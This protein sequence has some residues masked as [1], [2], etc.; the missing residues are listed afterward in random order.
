MSSENAPHSL[1]RWPHRS[2]GAALTLLSRISSTAASNSLA[3]KGFCWRDGT[4]P[5]HPAAES[6]LMSGQ[7]TFQAVSVRAFGDL[8]IRND[9]IEILFLKQ[10]LR[11]LRVSRRLN[12]MIAL[13]QNRSDGLQDGIVLIHE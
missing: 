10:S 13:A 11:F 6:R 4:H 12:S 3:L 8:H 5:D 2:M 9:Q 1:P 7:P